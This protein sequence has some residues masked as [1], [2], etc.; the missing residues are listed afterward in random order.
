MTT[1]LPP[2]RPSLKVGTGEQDND[3]IIEG[4][5]PKKLD[6]L[7]TAVTARWPQAKITT[8]SLTD[9]HCI[10]ISFSSKEERDRV[11]G[12]IT[13]P[14]KPLLADSLCATPIS[15]FLPP[16][17]SQ[18]TSASPT[19]TDGD[20]PSTL[21]ASSQPAS[22]ATQK[23][24]SS[25]SQ[26]LRQG[27]GRLT[28]TSLEDR[29]RKQIA[30]FL[31]SPNASIEGEL[32]DKLSYLHQIQDDA[33]LR[34]EVQKPKFYNIFIQNYDKSIFSQDLLKPIADLITQLHQQ[35]QS[36]S[37]VRTAAQSLPLQPS[38]PASKPAASTKTSTQGT[39]F[40]ERVTQGF[41]S[42]FAPSKP[43]ISTLRAALSDLQTEQVKL[44]PT[45]TAPELTK[46]L[47]TEKDSQFLQQIQSAAFQQEFSNVSTQIDLSTQA[48]RELKVKLQTVYD[49][50]RKLLPVRVEVTIGSKREAE[51]LVRMLR[52]AI[53]TR[54]GANLK[55][56]SFS[57]GKA[58][59]ECSDPLALMVYS[60]LFDKAVN[61]KEGQE[62]GHFV[63][64]LPDQSQ[65]KMT[66]LLQNV[67]KQNP[68]FRFSISEITLGQKRSV[69]VFCHSEEAKK[70]FLRQLGSSLLATTEPLAA[71]SRPNVDTKPSS[72]SATRTE[73]PSVSYNEEEYFSLPGSPASANGS[74]GS[75]G[76]S[77]PS[78]L[79]ESF[80]DETISQ[81]GL[82]PEEFDRRLA[83]IATQT[84]SASTPPANP[85]LISREEADTLASLLDP[86][87]TK[88]GSDTLK[89]KSFNQGNIELTCQD[90]VSLQTYK[91]LFA[92]AL[93]ATTPT[94][95]GRFV[96]QIPGGEKQTI[97]QL[98]QASYR[99]MPFRIGQTTIGGKAHVF[100]CCNS[101]KE[102]QDILDL[103]AGKRP[104]STQGRPASLS[105]LRPTV[106][107][108]S[109]V[110]HSGAIPPLSTVAPAA[111][112]LAV[113]PTTPA[114]PQPLSSGVVAAWALLYQGIR[115]Y[116]EGWL[117]GKEN[118][119]LIL[120]GKEYLLALFNEKD[121]ERLNVLENQKRASDQPE[122]QEL[123]ERK[124]LK[125]LASHLPPNTRKSSQLTTEN[126]LTMLTTLR[127]YDILAQGKWDL[128]ENDSR[129]KED[130]PKILQQFPGADVRFD[131]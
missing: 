95:L 110:S 3:L 1:P 24:H 94:A 48:T 80:H 54:T 59:L 33:Q 56:R 66:A 105:T 71:G 12:N 111:A 40:R 69:F 75:W 83:Q 130:V 127:T 74:E 61:A 119:A 117:A 19:S 43:Q 100:V 96:V 46:A 91:T 129:W 22:S 6:Q 85:I 18:T 44:Q 37:S 23:A 128:G 31:K 49:M 4:L 125:E 109:S 15:P 87:I 104:V 29:L 108:P 62:L 13:D 81:Q 38:A 34:E 5:D 107:A 9:Q 28:G 58:V 7:R 90:Q 72:T 47:K 106:V 52:P 55:V 97:L 68:Q 82:D 51:D 11:Y 70:A 41:T 32:F 60:Q 26:T 124:K 45:E 20:T 92:Q 103:L 101:Q 64:Q 121:Q 65:E 114:Q 30:V 98:I 50:L 16:N 102:R 2:S 84:G 21:I 53:R 73:Q 116:K 78:L 39:S 131:L 8:P 112:V 36:S 76:G 118:Q 42:L 126:L 27:W 99:S 10:V 86:A 93:S 122:I 120:A 123:Q 88:S 113:T 17:P 57:H 77:Q 79:S 14:R 35:G 115:K 63:I 25:T 89:I 67:K